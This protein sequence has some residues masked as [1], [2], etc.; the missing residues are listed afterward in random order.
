VLRVLSK[1]APQRLAVKSRIFLAQTS[2]K[3]DSFA[4]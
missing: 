4:A 1:K 3:E 2:R